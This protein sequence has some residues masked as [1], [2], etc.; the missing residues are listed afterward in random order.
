MRRVLLVAFVSVLVSGCSSSTAPAPI[1]G[2]WA[3]VFKAGGFSTV[4]TLRSSGSTVSGSGYWCG[5]LIPC[6]TLNVT[7]TTSGAVVH[8]ELTFS[9]GSAQ[10]FDGRLVD[11]VTLLGQAKWAVGIPESF[12]VTFKRAPGSEALL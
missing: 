3:E 1:D 10:T 12:E 5:E 7:G 4:M 9:N 6:G 2:R 11:D 8:L